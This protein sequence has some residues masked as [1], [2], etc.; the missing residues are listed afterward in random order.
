M[1]A[2]GAGF[3]AVHERK[4]FFTDFRVNIEVAFLRIRLRSELELRSLPSFRE[5]R[6]E[7]V[8]VP[9]GQDFI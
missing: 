5:D 8:T 7:R 9:I 3:G 6:R 4:I 1:K 2:C